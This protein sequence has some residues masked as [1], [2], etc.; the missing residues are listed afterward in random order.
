MSGIM[1]AGENDKKAGQGQTV[2]AGLSLERVVTEDV[3]KEVTLK[4]RP[5]G[6]EQASPVTLSGKSISAGRGNGQRKG[7]EDRDWG[8]GGVVTAMWLLS[9]GRWK[10]RRWGPITE[11]QRVHASPCGE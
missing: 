7:P 5:E 3:S 8:W 11:S 2:R 1:P 9:S 6:E 4:Q 10:G